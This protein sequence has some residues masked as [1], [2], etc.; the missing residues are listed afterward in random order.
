MKNFIKILLISLIS[1]TAFAQT[2]NIK[3]LKQPV[4]VYKDQ[5]GVSHIYAQNEHDLF[6]TQ[7]YMAA[8]D[9]LFQFE[10]WRRQATGTVAELL[11]E[12][13]LKRDI[14]TRLFKFRGN[15][16]AELQHYHPRSQQIIAAFVAGI[17]T[18]IAEARQKPD[19]L[20]FEFKLLNTLPDFWT[21]EI[22][23]SRHQG[24]LSNIEEEIN[25]ARLVRLL[26][27][28]KV[29]ELSWFHPKNSANEPNLELD[30]ILDNDVLFSNILEYYEA[31]RTPL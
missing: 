16:T 29:R 28:D 27:A 3:I 7:G 23:I 17:N 15:L 24:L 12:R 18:Y 9:R 13:E 10:M 4:E 20:P 5:W 30:K 31:F 6:V 25:N 8:S 19:E 11:G 1:I 26:G 14:G 22:V 21:P 2:V